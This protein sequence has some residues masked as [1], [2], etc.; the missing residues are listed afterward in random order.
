M[1]CMFEQESLSRVGRQFGQPLGDECVGDPVSEAAIT[2]A[3]LVRHLEDVRFATLRALRQWLRALDA[4][5]IATGTLSPD[6]ERIEEELV[7]VSGF[8]RCGESQ[9]VVSCASFSDELR[10][11]LSSRDDF[12]SIGIDARSP[13]WHELPCDQLLLVR[14]GAFER[15]QPCQVMVAQLRGGMRLSESAAHAIS[16]LLKEYAH[17]RASAVQK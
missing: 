15:S 5:R 4:E 9:R 13:A 12:V 16:I 11:W 6:G 14:G 8:G 3:A 17:R 1:L 7:W 10:T 2:G